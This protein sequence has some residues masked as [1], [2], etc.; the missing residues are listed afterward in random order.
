MALIYQH[1]ETGLYFGSCVFQRP[2]IFF[3]T[4]FGY[5]CS[6]KPRKAYLSKN[7]IALLTYGGVPKEFFLDLMESS[8]QDA[9][10]IC[11]NKRT[12]LRGTRRIENF[13]VCLVSW[14]YWIIGNNKHERVAKLKGKICKLISG[15]I[16]YMNYA[17]PFLWKNYWYQH[18]ETLCSISFG[19]ISWGHGTMLNS[20]FFWKS[21]FGW[22]TM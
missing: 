9:H 20:F 6:K 1:G 2:I 14:V 12:A 7:L 11:T 19:W 10:S 18:M 21:I 16:F 22:N 4:F 13:T 8:L 5:F 17:S 15:H 3:L